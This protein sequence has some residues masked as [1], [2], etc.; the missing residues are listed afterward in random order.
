[1]MKVEL[2]DTDTNMF[3]GEVENL[4]QVV[5]MVESIVRATLHTVEVWI[6]SNLDSM[7]AWCPISKRV[8]RL[9]T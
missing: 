8:V 5:S 4:C 3:L 1:M 7:Y 9:P 6:D 2:F